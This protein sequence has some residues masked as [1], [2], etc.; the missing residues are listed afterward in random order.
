MP[1]RIH[2]SIFKRLFLVW[3]ILSSLIAALVYIY[4]H[5]RVDTIAVN[6]A[7]THAS[8]LTDEQIRAIQNLDSKLIL[9]LQ[10]KLESLTQRAFVAA[11]IYDT[12]GNHV[13]AAVNFKNVKQEAIIQSRHHK[14]PLD[15]SFHYEKFLLDDK[16]MIQILVPLKTSDGRTH[17]YFEG[18]YLVDEQTLSLINK[19]I[20]YSITL[21]ILICLIT[22]VVLYP[23]ILRL[24]R[25]LINF[26]ENL[27][28]TNVELMEVLGCAIAC[29][30]SST[31]SHNYRVTLYAT[32]LGEK[33]GLSNQ[34]I[35][36]IILGSFLHD[37]GKIGIEDRI[38]KK[39]GSLSN[40]EIEM[41]RK[42]VEKGTEIISKSRLL[43]PAHDIITYHHEKF[44][45]S[46][47]CKNLKGENIPLSARIFA[48]AD[49][50]D[51]LVS[52]RVYKSAY[53]ID[54]ALNHIKEQSGKH[55]DPNI[56]KLFLPLAQQLYSE[57]ADNSDEILAK[58]LADE[59]ESYFFNV[60]MKVNIS[61]DS[62]FP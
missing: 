1:S 3:L 10:S 59:I 4:E 25:R 42:H 21:V 57:I 9:Q 22:G 52:E 12:E 17:G 55:F 18:V 61:N 51:A 7:R 34:A 28:H 56:V 46:G 11:D 35:R 37:V 49:V 8:T 19:R 58:K 31:N 20:Y 26:S 14:F 44:D 33:M 30:D 32:R 23:I 41:M 60:D 53:S 47:Y 39:T 54:Y 50:F 24:N 5:Q 38:L 27:I 2:R 43:Q 6:L 13:A 15:T 16:N 40:Q 29:R 45:G 62:H 36:E 48:I